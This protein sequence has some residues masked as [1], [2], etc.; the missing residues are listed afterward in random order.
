MYKKQTQVLGPAPEVMRQWAQS[1]QCRNTGFNY[2]LHLLN[3]GH[4]RDV[5]LVRGAGSTFQE[6]GR[7]TKKHVTP[8]G[9][10]TAFS[11]P[12]PLFHMDSGSALYVSHAT[13]SPNPQLSTFAF[14]LPSSISTLIDMLPTKSTPRRQVVPFLSQRPVLPP[15]S[16]HQHHPTPQP[17]FQ[18]SLFQF[19]RFSQ[20]IHLYQT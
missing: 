4:G 1:F 9:I 11:H 12:L 19:P 3:P 6:A 18:S 8:D 16:P 20:H 7:G 14:L 17:F 13:W 5:D 2:S 15:A 10:W